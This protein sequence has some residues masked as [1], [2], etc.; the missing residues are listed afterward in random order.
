MKDK[1]IN[2]GYLLNSDIALNTL[3][4]KSFPAINSIKEKDY[5][6]ISEHSIPS[7]QWKKL[8]VKKGFIKF[9]DENPLQIKLSFS[10]TL[11]KARNSE[12][13]SLVDNYLIPSIKLNTETK[14]INYNMIVDIDYESPKGKVVLRFLI[15]YSIDIDNMDDSLTYYWSKGIIVED[16]D[17]KIFDKFNKVLSE[18]TVLEECKIVTDGLEASEFQ[19]VH[20]NTIYLKVELAPEMFDQFSVKEVLDSKDN[21]IIDMMVKNLGYYSADSLSKK[22]GI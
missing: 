5:C 2:Y 19:R 12:M 4:W 9:D 8:K 15:P 11:I 20:P 21:A 1:R 22:L 10:D 6:K 18:D 14:V 13:A 16:N 3:A 7:N 17:S